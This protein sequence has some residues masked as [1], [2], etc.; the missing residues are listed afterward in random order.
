MEKKMLMSSRE[1]KL[2][3][4]RKENLKIRCFKER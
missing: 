2:L 4:Q 3:A 1:L